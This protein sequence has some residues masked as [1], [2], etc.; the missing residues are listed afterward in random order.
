MKALILNSGTGSRMG[1]YTENRPKCMVELMEGETIIKRQ[2]QVLKK[3]GIKEVVITTGPMEELLKNHVSEIAGNMSV[4]FVNNEKYQDTNYIYSIYLAR[5][6]LDDDILLLHG[7]LVF[8]EKVLELL[9]GNKD[10][11]VIV[12]TTI[13]LP[14]KDFKAVIKEERVKAVGIE[15]F[16]DAVPLQPLYLL[17]KNDWKMWLGKIV[18][19]C[20]NDDRKCY[21]EKA[22]NTILDEMILLPIDCKGDLCR[23]VDCE[24]DLM[25]VRRSLTA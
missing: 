2:F 4:S 19:F 16:E 12:D 11:G 9:L 15:F 21:A 17:R 24:E 13:E 8:D 18:E 7:D 14:E 10:S 20:E 5:E 3:A 6:L 1:K 25:A 23:E 22:L